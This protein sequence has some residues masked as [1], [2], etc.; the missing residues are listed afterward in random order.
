MKDLV[1][2]K[3]RTEEDEE[4]RMYPR[5]DFNNALAYLGASI[6]IMPLSMYKRL[7]MGKLE[8]INM[9]IEMADNTKCTPK[10]IVENLLVKIDKFIFLVDFV[11]LDMVEDFR[12]PIILGRPLLA[13]T[14]AKSIFSLCY[15]FRKSFSL[16]AMENKNPIRT[17]GD[18]SKPSH[19]GY[20]NTIEL[21]NGK[22]V[23]P[24]R[25]DTIRLVQN[26][27]SFHGLRSEDPNQHLKNFLKLV[28]SLD[29]D[30]ANRERTRLRLFQFAIRDPANVPSIFD[31]RLI[32]LKN[33]AQRLMEAHLAPKTPV[34]VHKIASSC[35][36]C[37]GPHDT[38]YCMKNPEQ[39]FVE[40]ASSRTD[41]AREHT[42]SVY[43]R[44]E[45]DKRRGVEYVM[46]KI[47]GFYNECLELGPEYLT[48]LEECEVIFDEKKLWSF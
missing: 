11:I 20:R 37:S 2:N 47:L 25:S 35:E 4:I 42:E 23:V 41:E 9:V 43:F 14:H 22:N 28:D 29:L 5:L 16:T 34:Q 48:G 24:L 1:A 3:P 7:G 45:D 30:V 12:I 8:P 44:N 39:A 32:E 27:S 36:I 6:S 18:Y 13:T 19:E 46:N 31:H 38:Q 33:Q 17:L 26:G 10:G 40:Y 15:L 21:L